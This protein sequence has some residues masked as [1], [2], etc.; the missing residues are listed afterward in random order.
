[1]RKEVEL[2]DV[3][4]KGAGVSVGLETQCDGGNTSGGGVAVLQTTQGP[5]SVRTA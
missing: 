4:V 2:D 1:M 5:C 3:R